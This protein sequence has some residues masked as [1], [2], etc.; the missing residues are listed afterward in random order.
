MLSD[1]HA[2]HSL[3]QAT[4]H[5]IGTNIYGH[6]SNVYFPQDQASKVALLDTMQMLNS[7]RAHPLWIL[8]GDFNM[9]TKLEEK[10]GGRLRLEPKCAHFKDFINN[11]WLIDIPFSN[12]IYTWNNKQT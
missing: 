4:F 7:N 9:I 2:A 8:G 11:F 6:L 10:T 12:D 5:P 1:F 3:I